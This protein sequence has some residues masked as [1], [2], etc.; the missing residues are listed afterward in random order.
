MNYQVLSKS[1]IHALEPFLFAEGDDVNKDVY[2]LICFK[3]DPLYPFLKSVIE[4][5]PGKYG[6][7]GSP[8]KPND[9]PGDLKK[10]RG[11][12]VL[13]DNETGTM[14]TENEIYLQ[15]HIPKGSM[16]KGENHLFVEI[17]HTP[18]TH[19][20]SGSIHYPPGFGG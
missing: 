14:M 15:F 4:V 13:F 11:L 12:H 1:Q 17:D 7:K 9:V 10:T 16:A 3:R 18:G 8:I 2:V 6:E 20:G 19:G 5:E